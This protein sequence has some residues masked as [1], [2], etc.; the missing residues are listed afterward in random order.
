VE[1]K[2]KLGVEDVG[3]HACE[4]MHIVKTAGSGAKNDITTWLAKDLG[5]FPLKTLVDLETPRGQKGSGSVIFRN[6]IKGAQDN[7]LFELPGDYKKYDNLVE[8][9]T[10]GR[11]GSRLGKPEDRRG[12]FKGRV[13]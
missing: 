1:K 12:I 4:K 10:E 9:A 5:G 7:S 3:G 2:E 8:L 11:A 6:I 13:K